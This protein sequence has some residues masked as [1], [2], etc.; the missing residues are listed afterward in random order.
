MESMLPRAAGRV[1]AP[2]QVAQSQCPRGRIGSTSS[3][4]GKG[5]WQG[6][7]SRT[8]PPPPPGL[9]NRLHGVC[10]LPGR[11]GWGEQ[12][13]SCPDSLCGG[14]PSKGMGQRPSPSPTGGPA[15]STTHILMASH[16]PLLFHPP[17]PHHISAEC[18]PHLLRETPWQS[19]AGSRVRGQE[20]EHSAGPLLPKPR[21]QRHRD[22]RQA[23]LAA[24]K[25]HRGAPPLGGGGVPPFLTHSGAWGTTGWAPTSQRRKQS[26]HGC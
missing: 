25:A 13:G 12:Q 18:W 14:S 15:Q 16:R 4:L 10:I 2:L 21:P 20:A 17:R 6:V 24:S 1:L 3:G 9:T 11:Q 19:E 7:G 8:L 26:L 22:R 23:A 5:V